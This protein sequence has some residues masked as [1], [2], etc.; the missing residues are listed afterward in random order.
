[1]DTFLTGTIRRNKKCI[2]DDLQ[3]TNVNEVKYFRKNEV[4]FCAFREK[5]TVKRPALLI[6]T[7]VEEEDVTIT[8]NRH[9]IEIRFTKPAIVQSYNA[10]MGGVGESDKMLYT[11]LDERRSVKYWK[12]YYFTYRNCITL[13]FDNT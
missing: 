5:K 6:S 4:L 12:K 10:F 2:P 8:K 1:M 3:Q 7:K 9:G 11:Y 13:D